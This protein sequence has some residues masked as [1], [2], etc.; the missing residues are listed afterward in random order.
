MFIIIYSSPR[1]Y[2]QEMGLLTKEPC[3]GHYAAFSNCIFMQCLNDCCGLN[4]YET[5]S[6]P[7]MCL[8]IG[9]QLMGFWE[10]IESQGL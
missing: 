9:C 5:C 2:Q 4:E 3:N 1:D 6:L 7:A 10:V 8:G